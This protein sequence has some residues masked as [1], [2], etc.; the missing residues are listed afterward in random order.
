MTSFAIRHPNYL[1]RSIKVKIHKILGNIQFWCDK[2]QFQRIRAGLEGERLVIKY[3]LII[4]NAS[5]L[6]P[7][8]RIWHIINPQLTNFW[9]V[10]ISQSWAYKVIWQQQWRIDRTICRLTSRSSGVNIGLR[11]ARAT[12]TKWNIVERDANL[13]VKIKIRQLIIGFVAALLKNIIKET[14]KKIKG[15]QK[16]RYL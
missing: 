5:H 1:I 7:G 15:R 9:T 16:N 3:R 6:N 8:A 14:W 2:C 4:A 10:V 13:C 11:R 12:L